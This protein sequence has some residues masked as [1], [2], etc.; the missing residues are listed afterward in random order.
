MVASPFSTS[1]LA[2]INLLDGYVQGRV[3]VQGLAS[4]FLPKPSV[5]LA[6][7]YCVIGRGS[8]IYSMISEM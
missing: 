4:I 3:L 2:Y 8:H 1:I 5:D 7:C 6:N